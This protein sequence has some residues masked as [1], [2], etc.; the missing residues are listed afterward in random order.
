MK[1]LFIPVAG[2]FCLLQ[3]SS[4]LNTEREVATSRNT[5]RQFTP[6]LEANRGRV[7][8]RTVLRTV[9]ASHNFSSP[10]AKD[11]F[12]LQ[13]RGP[14]IV[15]SRAYFIILNSEGDT[16]RQEIMPATV[17]M[18]DQDMTDPQTATVRDKEIAILQGMNSFF[19]DDRFVQ[20][21]VPKTAV[22]PEN[23]DAQ[24]WSSVKADTRSIGFDYS[25]ADGRERR[26]AYSKALKR[27]VVIAE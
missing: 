15:T 23:V 1:K 27:A 19:R 26:L 16:L 17:L 18:S 8:E 20:P 7:S 14:K 3:L 2:A 21:A 11:T 9:N 13:L 4:C 6:G 10:K 12:V 25:S 22:Q 5:D 24:S